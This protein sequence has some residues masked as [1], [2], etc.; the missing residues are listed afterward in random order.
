MAKILK[1]KGKEQSKKKF[2]KLR[3]IK[4]DLHNVAYDMELRFNKSDFNF[5]IDKTL[6]TKIAKRMRQ[7]ESML[8]RLLKRIQQDLL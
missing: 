4:D 5:K 3:K 7:T 2:L 6:A 8:Y 1:V